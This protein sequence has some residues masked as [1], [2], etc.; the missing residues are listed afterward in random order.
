M[1]TPFFLGN[2]DIDFGASGAVPTGINTSFKR[3]NWARYGISCA[4][5]TAYR[6]L[7][8][9]AGV[10]TSTW[11][12]FWI[13]QNSSGPAGNTTALFGLGLSSSPN[14]SF[15]LGWNNGSSQYHLYK[16]D[17]TTYTVLQTTTIGPPGAGALQS[18]WMNIANFG[19]TASVNIWFNNVLVISGTYNLT[20]TGMTT[21]F[22]TA[23]LGHNLQSGGGGQFAT[24]FIITSDDLRLFP[25]L[26]T[27][28]AVATGTT[29]Q[30]SNNTPANENAQNVST[31]S[32]I[33]DNTNGQEQQYTQTTPP[34]GQF[35]ILGKKRTTW[36]AVGAGSSV[37][38]VALGYRNVTTGNTTGYGTGSTKTLT[39]AYAPYEQYDMV[40]PTTGVA[41]T[42]G[43]ESAMQSS[44]KAIT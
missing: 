32:P 29:S 39:G 23:I 14:C 24:E 38:K 10:Q 28:V 16:W 34:T 26:Q 5:G 4:T 30:W 8:F 22:D 35:T 17:G 7:P 27:R 13:G 2:E 6:S 37:S 25:G 31:A 43:D 20:V 19:T 3:T 1:A 18:I 44:V 9:T 41:F 11:V 33:F 40:D 12:S 36:A 15:G 42:V 21:G